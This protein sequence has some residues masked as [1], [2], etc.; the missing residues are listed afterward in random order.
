MTLE[1]RIARQIVEDV[2]PEAIKNGKVRLPVQ[3]AELQKRW[4]DASSDQLVRTLLIAY[5]L[6]VQEASE[7]LPPTNRE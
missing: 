6:L 3:M 7:A 1:A 4:P 5:E 2:R